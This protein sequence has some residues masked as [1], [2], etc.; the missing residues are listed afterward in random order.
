[1][2]R[3]LGNVVC[4]RV[5][6]ETCETQGVLLLKEQE[7][8]GWGISRWP[9]QASTFLHLSHGS[10]LLIKHHPITIITILAM[11]EHILVF[12]LEQDFQ[13]QGVSEAILAPPC[14]KGIDI[15]IEDHKHVVPIRQGFRLDP[16]SGH[17]KE[18]T[19]E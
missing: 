1:M 11:L 5:A 2:Q 6:R 17:T 18:S 8:C 9:K 12:C 3:G 19:N 16:Q 14:S 4:G 10:H 13:G 7:Q 15:K